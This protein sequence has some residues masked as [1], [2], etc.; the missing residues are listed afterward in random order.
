MILPRYKIFLIILLSF[1][2][3][4]VVASFIKIDFFVVFC[5]ILMAAFFLFIAWSSKK[6]RLIS[7]MLVFVSLG[8]LRYNLSWSHIEP[9]NIQFYNGQKARIEGMVISVEKKLDQIEIV[10]ESEKIQPEADLLLTEIKNNEIKKVKGKVLVYAPL[11][12]NYQYG[13]LL[14]ISCQLYQPEPIA[15][16]PYHEYLAKQD[17]YSTCFSKEIKILAQGKG[18]FFNRFIFQTRD[19]IKTTI[20]KTMTEPESSIL[21]TLLLGIGKETPAEVRSWFSATGTAHILSISGLHVAILASLLIYLAINFLGLARPKAFYFVVGTLIFYILLA[22]SPAAAVR[23]AIMGI[24]A[25][26]AQKI[27]R[28]TQGVNLIIFAAAIMLLFNPKLLK[29]DMGFQLS[30]LAILGITLL[31]DYFLKVFN[32]LKFLPDKL[33]PIQDYLATTCSAYL[34][35]LPLVLFYF[36]NLSLIAPIANILILPTLPF[37]MGLGFIFA[38]VSL[39]Y[40]GLAQILA[41]PIWV[42]LRYIVLVVKFLALV[43]YFS[44]NLGKISW[45]LMILMYLLLIFIVIKI[46]RRIYHAD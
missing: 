44:F 6:I 8:I 36:G 10:L 30:F 43:P 28:K 24:L 27:G 39:I 45:W 17:I 16:F 19:R 15:G 32:F 12:S 40:F 46:K 37:L 35:S 29:S 42:I 3:G 25:I 4:I 2:V 23:S 13:D 20:E 14:G 26:F 9:A 22:G 11:F 18:N 38:L 5:A 31:N 41:W 1:I 7:F 34:F 33:R 21:S